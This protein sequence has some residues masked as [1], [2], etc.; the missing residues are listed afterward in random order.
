MSAIVGVLPARNGVF[1]NSASITL[2]KVWAREITSSA[3]NEAPNTVT[4]RAAAGPKASGPAA[5]DN[6]RC[7]RAAAAGSSGSQAPLSYFLA[8]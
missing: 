5:T 1:A 7:T 2:S 4:R 3:L 6:Q 8:R